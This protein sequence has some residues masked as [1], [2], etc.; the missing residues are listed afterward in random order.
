V[1]L[2]TVGLLVEIEIYSDVVCPWCYLGK[3]RLERALAT[4]PGEVTLRWR[5]FQLDP[6]MPHEC[7]PLL[8]WLGQRFGG[9][10]RARQ[11]MGHVTALAAAEGLSLD[12]DRALIANTFDAHRLLWFADQ[13]ETVVFGAGPDTQA[14]LADALHRAHFTDGLDIGSMH[15]L[16]EIADQVGLDPDRTHQFLTSNEGTA[17]VRAQI[18]HAHDVGITSVPTFVFAGKYA[19]TGAQETST[20]RGVLDEVARREGMAPDMRSFIPGQRTTAAQ[21]DD[22]SVA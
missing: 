5:A 2:T 3:T 18:A 1:L 4:Y 9:E 19:V 21:Q 11:I 13:P 7:Q 8:G 10:E 16:V 14:E 20:L 6:D 17:D 22:P 12:F 15:T